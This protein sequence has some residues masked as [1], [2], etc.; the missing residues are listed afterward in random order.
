MLA[1]AAP[2]QAAGHWTIAGLVLLA[3][4]VLLRR[5]AAWLILIVLPLACGGGGNEIRAARITEFDPTQPAFTFDA[6]VGAGD[7]RAFTSAG[8]PNVPIAALGA[9]IR[10]GTLTVSQRP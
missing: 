6:S 4:L 7:V 2:V 8:D 3:P 1:T 5:R 10:A 9:T